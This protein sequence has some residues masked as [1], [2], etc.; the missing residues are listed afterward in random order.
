[1]TALIALLLWE[2]VI[3]GISTPLLGTFALWVAAILTLWSM[4]H[5]LRL[6]APHFRVRRRG[7]RSGDADAQTETDRQCG[8]AAGAVETKASTDRSG[9]RPI[10]ADACN[11]ES[12]RGA[13]LKCAPRRQRNTRRRV[14]RSPIA[15]LVERRTV[16]PQVPGSSPGRGAIRFSHHYRLPD[17]LGSDEYNVE[18][19][20]RRANA[21]KSYLVGKG[22]AADRLIAVGGGTSILSSIATTALGPR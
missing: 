15:Q 14:S 4:F 10:V 19:S 17:R 13:M 1:M 9:A 11:G 22:V 7:A 8:A 12:G 21:V 2:N 16:N 3:P 20:Q 6:A 18:L 5:Y